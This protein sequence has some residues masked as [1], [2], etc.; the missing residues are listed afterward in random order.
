MHLN[1]RSLRVVEAMIARAEGRRVELH[2]IEKGGRFLDCGIKTHGGL[3][4]GIDLAKVCLADLAHVSVVPGTVGGRACPHIQVITDHPVA[5][6]LASQYAGWQISEGKFFAMGSGP[7]RAAYGHEPIFS[8]IGFKEETHS[9]VGVLEGRKPPTTAVIAKIAKACNVP[10]SSVTLLVAPTA[11][12]AGTLQVVARSV[13]TALHKLHELHFDMTRVVSAHGVAPLPPV[14][15]DDLAAIGRTNDSILYGA[16]VVLYVEGDDDSIEEIGPQVPSSS[17]KDHG[18]PFATIFAR[19][20]ND[21]Y[22]V[23]PHLFSP[24][25]VVFQNIETGKVHSFGAVDDAVLARS[26]YQ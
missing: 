3:R 24:A 12:L 25:E 6:C 4:A 15:K 18:D 8:T 17:S 10:P 21:F 20:N 16:R 22:A 19:Y 9:V 13:E 23:D 1:G 26:F 14:A 2:P 11:S 7:M 5:A